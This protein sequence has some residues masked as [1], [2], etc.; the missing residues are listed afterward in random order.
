MG[1]EHIRL[2]QSPDAVATLTI[3][4]PDRLNALSAQTVD[5]LRAAVE[6][7]RP[8]PTRAAF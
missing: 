8:D 6:R 3:D 5:E 7:G 1:F 4:R 2:E